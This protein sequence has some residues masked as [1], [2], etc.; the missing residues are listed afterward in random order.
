[1]EQIIISGVNASGTIPAYQGQGIHIKSIEINLPLNQVGTNDPTVTLSGSQVGALSFHGD[2][3][4]EQRYTYGEEVNITSANFSGN[5][6][7]IIRYLRYGDQNC[8]RY[9]NSPH[10]TIPI[11][12]RLR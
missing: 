8:E 6:S 3:T 7:A 4:L 5:Y 1:M 12:W 10:F 2:T 11:P 9:I